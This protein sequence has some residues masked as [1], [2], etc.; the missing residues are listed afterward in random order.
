VFRPLPTVYHFSP[1]YKLTHY[2]VET[3]EGCAMTPS[4]GFECPLA[5]EEY[6]RSHPAVD[7][8]ILEVN[9]ADAAFLARENGV[10][11]EVGDARGVR[12]VFRRTPTLPTYGP[13]VDLSAQKPNYLRQDCQFYC[14]VIAMHEL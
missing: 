7:S 3:H 8:R 1:L 13:P 4:A 14:L 6:W 11:P 12:S 10:L 5:T 2:R 9:E